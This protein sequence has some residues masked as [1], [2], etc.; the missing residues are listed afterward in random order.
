MRKIVPYLFALALTGLVPWACTSPKL[1]LTYKMLIYVQDSLGVVRF[2]DSVVT[3]VFYADT[4]DWQVASY[5]DAAAGRITSRH[6]NDSRSSQF[7][8]QR[9]VPVPGEGEIGNSDGNIG[10][11]E[12]ALVVGPLQEKPVLMVVCDVE[13][14]CYAWRQVPVAEG[15]DEIYIKL[16]FR[17]W[18]SD[19]QVYTESRWNFVNESGSA[20]P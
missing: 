16:Y 13:H 9:M 19:P 7:M 6:G 3:Y 17:P 12:Q 8:V 2:A 14:R 10:G 11:T 20:T 1:K 5:R 18:K 15:L 4:A